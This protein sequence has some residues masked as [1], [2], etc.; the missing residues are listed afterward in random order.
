[1]NLR[2]IAQHLRAVHQTVA[3]WV[4]A[5][6]DALPGIPPVLERAVASKFDALFTLHGVKN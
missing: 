6:A 3:D 2:R 5:H 4:T 1:M